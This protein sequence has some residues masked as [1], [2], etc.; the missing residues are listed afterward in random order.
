M[1]IM[2]AWRIDSFSLR[3]SL[4]V[5]TVSTGTAYFS[6]IDEVPA[7]LRPRCRFSCHRSAQEL[8]C[9]RLPASPGP[10]TGSPAACCWR[11]A[12]RAA[13]VLLVPPSPGS[14]AATTKGAASRVRAASHLFLYPILQVMIIVS[15]VRVG[16]SV[17]QMHVPSARGSTACSRSEIF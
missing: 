6:S 5:Y 10:L 13:P 4:T 8:R 16:D 1:R 9:R 12:P 7:R 11:A 14:P 3:Q 15:V 17:G 2:R